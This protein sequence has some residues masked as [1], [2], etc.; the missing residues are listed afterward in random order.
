MSAVDRPSA[1]SRF[2]HRPAV[3]V[4][5]LLIRALYGAA[6]LGA[7]LSL[8]IRL[9]ALLEDPMPAAIL[10]LTAAMLFLVATSRP[11]RRP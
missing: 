3:D 1:A 4:T 8:Y 7:A 10:T 9:L 6:G 11:E 2:R 5:H